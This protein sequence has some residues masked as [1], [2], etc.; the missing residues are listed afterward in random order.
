[1][2]FLIIFLVFIF[3]WFIYIY[4]KK[5]H[6]CMYIICPWGC[7]LTLTFWLYLRYS[8]TLNSAGNLTW[9]N[10]FLLS[11]RSRNCLVS[12]VVKFIAV[13]ETMTAPEMSWRVCPSDPACPQSWGTLR[14]LWKPAMQKWGHW[15]NHSVKSELRMLRMYLQQYRTD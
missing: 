2:L 6:Q 3:A 8:L 12:S 15:L 11:N 1:M 10:L 13:W 4:V 14:R 7:G 5:Y 9:P